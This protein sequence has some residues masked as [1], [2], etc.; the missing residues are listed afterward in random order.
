MTALVKPLTWI[1][2]VVLLVVGI[3]GFVLPSPLLG[4]FGVDTIHNVVHILSGVVALWAASSG[5][6]YSR[7]YLMVFGIVYLIVA[8]LGF[9]TGSFLSIFPVDMNDNYLHT[10]IGAVC[11]IAAFGSHKTA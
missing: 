2:G 6:Q 3:L 5:Y 10:V 7:L 9:A 1:F 11:L 8:V 4:L